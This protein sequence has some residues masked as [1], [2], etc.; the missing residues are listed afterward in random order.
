[1]RYSTT[2]LKHEGLADEQRLL[3]CHKTTGKLKVDVRM[4]G[5]HRES[6][7]I[8]T[9]SMGSFRLPFGDPLDSDSPWRL[10]GAI[11][12]FKMTPKE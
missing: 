6:T 7:W 10:V 11:C 3:F 1:M 12:D 9:S 4:T 5:S 2:L 8:S